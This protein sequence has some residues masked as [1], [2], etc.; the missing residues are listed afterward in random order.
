MALLNES[1]NFKKFDTR[2]VERNIARGVLAPHELS[3]VLGGLPD[4]SENAEWIS[5]EELAE[6]ISSGETHSSP[7]M[8][9]KAPH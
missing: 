9:G 7:V 4:D 1:V 6:E 3:E 5:V 8:N 2:M